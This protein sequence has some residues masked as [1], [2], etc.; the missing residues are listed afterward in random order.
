MKVFVIAIVLNNAY[1]AFDELK[2]MRIT[3]SKNVR[4]WLNEN[5][6]LGDV[7]IVDGFKE[8]FLSTREISKNSALINFLYKCEKSKYINKSH[9]MSL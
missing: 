8:I 5:D 1:V 2:S 6:L 3:M 9:I 7:M 4:N